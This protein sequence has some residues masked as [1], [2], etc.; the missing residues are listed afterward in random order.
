[1][2][3][4]LRQDPKAKNFALNVFKFLKVLKTSG[5][6]FEHP[7]KR[8]MSTNLNPYIL[9]SFPRISTESGLMPNIGWFY[10]ID[11]QLIYPITTS[12]HQ[13]CLQDCTIQ[14]KTWSPRRVP[15]LHNTYSSLVLFISI[16]DIYCV[17]SMT[18]LNE[19]G[20]LSAKWCGISV[21]F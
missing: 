3:A 21:N 12:F 20:I 16:S 2:I 5:W 10:F 19:F 8:G 1:M 18:K 9:C 17:W 13:A 7:R 14:S 4:S 11:V 6:T 15:S